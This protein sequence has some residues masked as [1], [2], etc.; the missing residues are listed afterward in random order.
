MLSRTE[1]FHRLDDE[2]WKCE[3]TQ[4]TPAD[5]SWMTSIVAR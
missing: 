5:V 4:A 2:Q 1:N 3:I